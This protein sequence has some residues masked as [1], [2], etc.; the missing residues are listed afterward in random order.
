MHCT[1]VSKIHLAKVCRRDRLVFD[2]AGT[3]W[4][5]WCCSDSPGH[6]RA[7]PGWIMGAARLR[8]YLSKFFAASK[9]SLV[10]RVE[11]W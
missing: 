1:E 4:P 3:E 7:V 5:M 11:H 2:H 6:T 8:T 9:Y 10:Y